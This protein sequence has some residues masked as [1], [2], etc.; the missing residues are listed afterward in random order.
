[1][2]TAVIYSSFCNAE[3]DSSVS[4]ILT[5]MVP[6]EERI[7]RLDIMTRDGSQVIEAGQKVFFRVVPLS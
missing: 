5:A 7:V 4:D 6:Y 3:S 2:R 1:M